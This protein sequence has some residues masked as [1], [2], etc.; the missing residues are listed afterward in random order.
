V[1]VKEIMHAATIIDPDL[2]VLEVAK[3]MRD[4][5]IGSVLI[6]VDELDWGIVT[7]RDVI[8]K[9][10]SKDLDP[11][12]IKASDIMTEL[13]YTID[14]NASIHKASEI[15]NIHPIRRLPVMENGEIIGMVTSR[16]VAKYCVFRSLKH[17]RGY[18]GTRSDRKGLKFV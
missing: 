11:K 6:K 12:M 18:S 1:T 2:S 10:I 5:N 8:V 4:K 13:R 14:S 7:E 15:F 16:S 3:M 9:V 17:T